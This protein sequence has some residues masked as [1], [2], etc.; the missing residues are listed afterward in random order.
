MEGGAASLDD[1]AML[2]G[3]KPKGVSRWLASLRK[4]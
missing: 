2:S 3:E 4:R 1:C